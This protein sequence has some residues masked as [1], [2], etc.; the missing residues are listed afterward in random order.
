MELAVPIFYDGAIYTE[1]EIKKPKSKVLKQTH[2]VLAKSGVYRCMLVFISGCVVAYMDTEGN[3]V[4]DKVM[5]R[6]LTGHLPFMS[7]E[8][9][10]LKIIA[11]ING[12]DVVEGIYPCPR[13]G[14]KFVAEYDSI[15]E[16]DKRDRIS[17]LEVVCMKDYENSIEIKLTE[18]VKI[19]RKGTEEIIENIQ[20][21]EMRYPTINDCMAG[22]AK[23]GKGQEAHLQ[24]QV[25]INAIEKVNGE[26]IDKTWKAT[27]AK[28]LFDDM[29]TDDMIEIGNKIQKYGL[30]KMVERYCRECTK[31]WE[32][33]ISTSNF[34]VSGL[35]QT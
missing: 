21:F 28:F 4:D 32:A 24:T 6:K 13:C 2:E 35:K 11:T 31:V 15:T 14:E 20:T 17:E 22:T 34:F 19:N 33:P 30:N 16:E 10:S 12:D 9:V 23:F 29:E 3:V 8:A 26:P 27:Y 18:P 25:Y 7:A 1:A 5:I